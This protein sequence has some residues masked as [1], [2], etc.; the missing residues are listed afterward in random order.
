MNNEVS[1][2]IQ[3][4]SINQSPTSLFLGSPDGARFSSAE[5]KTHVT[6]DIK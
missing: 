5:F 2:N 1:K 6:L 3:S 4:D